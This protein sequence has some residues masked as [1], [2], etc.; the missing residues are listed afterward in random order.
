MAYKPFDQLNTPKAKP[1][2][3]YQPMGTPA[4]NPMD[5]VQ[6]PQ[7]AIPQAQAKIPAPVSYPGLVGQI[8]QTSTQGTPEVQRATEDVANFE[9]GYNRQR[10]GRGLL[11]N[12]FNYVGSL[13]SL[14]GNRAA[15][16]RGVYQQA[17]SNALT[18]QGQRISGLGTAA[19]YAAPTQVSPGNFY[20]NPQTGQDVSGGTIDP[21]SGG[22]RQ[23]RVGQGQIYANNAP[24]ISS[25]GTYSNNVINL[26]N[27]GGFNQSD[28]N[29]YNLIHNIANS[30]T[31]NP[32]YAQLQSNF[33]TALG[34]YAQ[35]LGQ[36]PNQLISSLTSTGRANTV[37]EAL[38]NLDKMAKQQN[39]SLRDPSY[40]N[41]NVPP[42]QPQG[43]VQSSGQTSGGN[44]YQIIP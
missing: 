9:R 12:P 3:P 28:L 42:P 35:V 26:L 15:Q 10:A 31:S 18:S 1:I 13:D 6:N 17:L 19:G 7:K 5:N 36:D 24:L 22:V 25:A 40:S 41:I 16:D 27:Q 37:G 33:N 11:A 44:S 21:F 8:A 43:G 14:A 4:V 34:N 29:V 20:V 23:G 39:E 38:A 30:N 2:T 32:K